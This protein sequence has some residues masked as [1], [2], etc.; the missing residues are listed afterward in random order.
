VSHVG[1]TDREYGRGS[2]ALWSLVLH[3][4]ILYHFERVMCLI[5]NRDWSR[6][7]SPPRALCI[8]VLSTGEDGMLRTNL[9]LRYHFT[10]C[11]GA[12]SKTIA[13]FFVRQTTFIRGETLHVQHCTVVYH[14]QPSTISQENL[15]SVRAYIRDFVFLEISGIL[16][17]LKTTGLM[18]TVLLRA[19]QYR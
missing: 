3:S 10:L 2:L 16:R 9:L 11:D 18:Y 12:R 7:G 6:A 14:V 17:S 13:D 8:A 5:T 15:C 1:L 4:T 19:V